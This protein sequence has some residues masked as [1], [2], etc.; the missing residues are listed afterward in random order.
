ML[1]HELA[2]PAVPIGV[3]ASG[4]RRDGR[5]EPAR[6]DLDGVAVPARLIGDRFDVQCVI[7]GPQHP[8]VF[9]GADRA[10]GVV[11]IENLDG[12]PISRDHVE[13]EQP[14]SAP[15]PCLERFG[16]SGQRRHAEQAPA[17]VEKRRDLLHG[18]P[19]SSG[20]GGQNRFNMD[21]LH[22]INSRV[23]DSG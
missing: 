9:V 14:T 13:G 8:A 1:V 20:V 10:G 22:A 2:P 15:V 18:L 5:S 4:K 21:A 17:D 6:V 12:V 7:P 19:H 23:P 16:T 3:D 11:D